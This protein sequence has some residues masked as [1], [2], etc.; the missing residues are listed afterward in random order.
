MTMKNKLYKHHKSKAVFVLRRFSF[1][2][3]AIL[4]AGLT[5][6]IP[7]YISSLQ[8]SDITT[9]AEDRKTETVEEKD[10]TEESLLN[11]NK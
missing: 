4:G 9:K 2:F 7:T 5:I 8:E 10:S 11:Y 3:L 1:V 6:G